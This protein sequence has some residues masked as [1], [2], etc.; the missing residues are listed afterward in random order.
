PS[1]FAN[2]PGALN[3]YRRLRTLYDRMALPGTPDI[4]DVY[5]NKEALN[6]S[7]ILDCFQPSPEML[8]GNYHFVGFP[9]TV[10]PPAEGKDMIYMSMGTVV[11][12]DLALFRLALGVLK[13]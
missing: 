7:F 3:F 6:I 9:M 12:K 11:N 2:I 1:L 5:V 8:T 4:W 10:E 13:N